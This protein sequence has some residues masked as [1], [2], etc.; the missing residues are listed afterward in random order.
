[1]HAQGQSLD[2]FEMTVV[3]R[4]I[5]KRFRASHRGESIGKYRRI[6]PAADLLDCP[7][8]SPEEARE[9]GGATQSGRD[10]NNGIRTCRRRHLPHLG[11]LAQSSHPGSRF[12][13]LTVLAR[14]GK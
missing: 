9:C 13:I 8:Q 2:D 6:T 4:K 11:I 3:D 10:M 7:E 12:S 14:A 1:M 5:E